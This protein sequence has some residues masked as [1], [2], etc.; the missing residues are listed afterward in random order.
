MARG[1]ELQRFAKE[2]DLVLLSVADVVEYRRHTEP[3]VRRGAEI[4]L[5]TQHGPLRAI[6]Y[7][8]VHDGAEHLAVISDPLDGNTPVHIHVECLAGDVL[9]STACSCRRRLD[10]ALTRVATGRGAMIYLRPSGPFQLCGAVRDDPDTRALGHWIL[11]DLRTHGPTR[12]NNP[13]PLDGLPGL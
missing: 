5:P 7:L 13:T 4:A 12:P 10:T 1:A 9:G 8:G 11:D 2:H 3:Q 6:G